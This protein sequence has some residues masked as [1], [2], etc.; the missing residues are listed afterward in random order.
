MSNQSE[1]PRIATSEAAGD[2]RFQSDPTSLAPALSSRPKAAAEDLPEGVKPLAAVLQEL[3]A[4]VTLSSASA[5]PE[6]STYLVMLPAPVWYLATDAEPA[7][8]NAASGWP[9][10]ARRLRA[11]SGKDWTEALLAGIELRRWWVESELTDAFDRHER[12]AIMEFDG[13][14]TRETAEHAVGLGE[15]MTGT[16]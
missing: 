12:A 14:L 10:R 13:G 7:G 9:A 3:A 16:S 5:R 1:R 11:P 2:E 15:I 6:G 4:V 8:D